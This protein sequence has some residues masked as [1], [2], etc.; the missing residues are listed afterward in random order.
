MRYKKN[1]IIYAL[2]IDDEFKIEG[3]AYDIGNYLGIKPI[4]VYGLYKRYRKKITP[5]KYENFKI[6]RT[7]I[8]GD[9]ER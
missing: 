9:E 2:Y 3:N 1:T 7:D 8:Y 6:I 5:R 4:S